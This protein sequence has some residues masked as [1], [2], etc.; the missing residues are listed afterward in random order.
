MPGLWEI[1][2]VVAVIVIAVVAARIFRGGRI[3]R[4]ENETSEG[5]P[6]AAS[7]LPAPGPRRIVR[8]TGFAGIAVG[9]LLLLASVTLVQAAF[10]IYP[11][12][13]AVIIIGGILVFLTRKKR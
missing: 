3:A 9:I 12:A 4:R 10:K 1:I 6:A 11:W 2:L 5:N 7:S 8:R 13:L